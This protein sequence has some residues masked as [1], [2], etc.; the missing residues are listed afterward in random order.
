MFC[1]KC[2]IIGVVW[3]FFINIFNN[4]MWFKRVLKFG[5]LINF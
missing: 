5:G 1:L 4:N 3:F 2:K